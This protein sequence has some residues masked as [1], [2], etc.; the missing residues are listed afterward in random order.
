MIKVAFFDTKDY[1]RKLFD[2]YN[3]NFKYEI[4]YFESKLNSETAQLAKGYDAV[5]ICFKMCRL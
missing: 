4:T 1:D 5:C 3:K 2:K